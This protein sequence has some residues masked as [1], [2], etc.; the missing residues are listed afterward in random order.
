MSA[1]DDSLDN[2]NTQEGSQWDGS[3]ITA[4]C[5]T[6]S[7]TTAIRF[8]EIKSGPGKLSIQQWENKFVGRGVLLDA[9]RY[10]SEQGRRIDPLSEKLTP[11]PS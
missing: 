6:S 3:A 7:S 11:S 10:C 9:F 4:A 5:A 2:Y 1:L 8:E